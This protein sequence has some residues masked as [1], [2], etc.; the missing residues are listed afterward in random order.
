MAV[1]NA[2]I[3]D[4]KETLREYVERFTRASVEIQSAHDGLKCFIFKSNLHD[5]CKFKEDL[6]VRAAKDMNNLPTCAQPYTNYEEKKLMEEA[7]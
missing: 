6:G 3:Q 1:L 4:K 7:Q 2:V 5:Y